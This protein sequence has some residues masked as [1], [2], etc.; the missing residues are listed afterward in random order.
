MAGTDTTQEIVPPEH[1]G[2]AIVLVGPQLAENIG[3]V[4]RAM[5]N[6]ALEDLRLVRPR[7]GWPNDKAYPMA[8]GAGAVLDAARVFDTVEEAIH[9]L[10]Y[11]LATTARHRDMVKDEVT[12]RAAAREIRRREASGERSGVLFGP[13]RIGLT[14]DE[15]VL[16]NA[17]LHVPLN[18]AFASLNLAQAV[19][20]VAYE[21]FQAADETPDIQR[22]DTGSRQ[23][24]GGE[25]VGFFEHLEAALEHVGFFRTPETKP[26]QVRNL[27]SIFGRAELTEQ[28]VR[29]LHGVVTMLVG[30]R[31]DQLQGSEDD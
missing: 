16:A 20:L 22:P 17:V 18:P 5:R 28:E 30:R 9:D 26:T 7:D 10:R 27:R 14:N 15:V 2:P 24:T 3:A 19:L 4:A 23:A 11:V 12:P 8:S 31:K 25:L 29:S 6:S 13:E 21:Y 1:P